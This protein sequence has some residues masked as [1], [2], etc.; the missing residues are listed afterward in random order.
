[1]ESKKSET[2]TFSTSNV[3]SVPIWDSPVS[4]LVRM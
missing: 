4:L 2:E 3:M 1:M